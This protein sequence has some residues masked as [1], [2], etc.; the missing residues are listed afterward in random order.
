[1][2]EKFKQFTSPLKSSEIEWKIQ[3]FTKGAT[4]RTIVV[5]YIDNRA[6]MN[7]LDSVFG[8]ESWSSEF[9]EF[10]DGVLCKLSIKCGDVW[11]TKCD[12]A[13]K[14]DIEAT[15]GGI[16]DSM[17]RASTQ[18]GLGRELYD[19][20]R[21]MVNGEIKFINKGLR[22]LLDNIDLSGEVVILD[23]PK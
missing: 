6:V 22:K 2:E 20:P 17:K 3:S 11:V 21:V 9:Q 1:M 15:K 14:T 23:S 19:Y 16:S 10:G 7:R 18:W 13:D 4:V 5:P 12:G 8:N